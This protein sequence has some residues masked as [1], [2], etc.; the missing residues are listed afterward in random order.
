MTK[1]YPLLFWLQSDPFKIW[2]LYLFKIL[3]VACTYSHSAIMVCSNGIYAFGIWQISDSPFQRYF[4][5]SS[6]NEW[7]QK[8]LNLKDTSHILYNYWYYLKF[9]HCIRIIYSVIDKKKIT[10]SIW[11]FFYSIY[12]YITLFKFRISNFHCPSNVRTKSI[13][14]FPRSSHYH[15]RIDVIFFYHFFPV[16][17]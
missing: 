13:F 15:I 5:N 8:K 14:L 7:L 2:D 3:F 10:Y 16:F 11:T 12:L 4:C 1:W 17:Q 9:R 6:R